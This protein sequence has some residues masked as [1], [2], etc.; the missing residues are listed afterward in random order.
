MQVLCFKYELE[1]FSW[2]AYPRDV[3][4]EVKNPRAGVPPH[5]KVLKAKGQATKQDIARETGL[6][7]VTVGTALQH[8]LEA[9]SSDTMES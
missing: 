2:V 7:F 9:H 8:L 4:R 1:F 5:P 6:S 3:P